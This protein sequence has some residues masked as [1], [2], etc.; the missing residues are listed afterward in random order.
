MIRDKLS[1]QL[2][3]GRGSAIIL[4]AGGFERAGCIDELSSGGVFSAFCGRYRYWGA[5]LVALINK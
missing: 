2:L 1:T 5:A 3:R 4:V